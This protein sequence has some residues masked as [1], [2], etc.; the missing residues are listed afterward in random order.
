MPSLTS[1]V[2][3]VAVWAVASA[4]MIKITAKS[5]NRFDPNSVTA[6]QGDLLEFHFEASNHS[7]VAGDYQYP[8]SPLQ[9]GT[10]FFSGFVEVS[11]GESDKVFRVKVVNT[12][13]MPF[14]SSQENECA[15]GMVG[16]INPNTN[17]TLDDYKSRASN[18]ARAVTP[19]IAVYGGD[20]VDKDSSV[21]NNGATV[22]STDSK[23]NGKDGKTNSAGILKVSTL[24]AA[25]VPPNVKRLAVLALNQD[26]SLNFES[27]AVVTHPMVSVYYGGL[28]QRS[29]SSNS[30][31]ARLR[32]IVP[33]VFLG[34][35]S[36]GPKN[37]ITDVPGVRVHMQSIHSHDG[38]VNTGVTTIVPRDDW[39][40]KAC[41]A[42]IFRFNGSGEMTGTHWIEETGL[43]H[44]PIILTNSFAVGPAYT[45]IYQH[46]LKKYK[47]EDG[48]V[49]WF[50]LPVVGETFDGHLNDLGVSAVTPEHI[51][52]G[53]ENATSDAVQ[54]GNTGGG[55]GMICQGFKGGTGTSSR[56]VPAAKEG[57]TYT[58]AALVQA[59]YGRRHHLRISGVPVGRIIAD[60]AAKK[61]A[62]A[63]QE[64]PKNAA[65]A[66]KETRDGSIIV[67]IATDAPLHPTSFSVSRSV[68]QS[69]LREL[70]A[71]KRMTFWQARAKRVV[72]SPTVKLTTRNVASTAC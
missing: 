69:V 17:Q 1:I 44:S 54:E 32:D 51:V 65:D 22:N 41:H 8:C 25:A 35:W 43:L 59:N 34:S 48:E 14:Y 5:D 7:V 53:L 46:A 36:P 15:N 38:N 26:H 72:A 50:L 64:V 68:P 10:G 24:I 57:K 27:L 9:L 62:A 55:T 45:G 12:D 29:T 31:R 42:G 18:L 21:D 33:S 47:G 56:L 60:E 39:F 28:M 13:P 66:S 61:A 23:T 2:A 20:L 16:I 4:N 63:G 58:V 11:S 37:G 6:E 67:I 70:M 3:G 52:A 40:H 19:G 49:G 71:L 30:P